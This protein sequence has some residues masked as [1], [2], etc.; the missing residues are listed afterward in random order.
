MGITYSPEFLPK[1]ATAFITSGTTYKTQVFDSPSGAISP[2]AANGPVIRLTNAIA[3]VSLTLP[4]M[5]T[6]SGHTFYVDI[7]GR[8]VTTKTCVIAANGSTTMQII[9]DTST[10]A[11]V[12]GLST[13]LAVSG[14]GIAAGT[15]ISAIVPSTTYTATAITATYGQT[16]AV[17]A[18]S[19]NGSVVTYSCA[20][21]ANMVIGQ[22]VTI[23]GATN[24]PYNGTY[25]VTGVNANINFTVA[26]T[27]TGTTSS[28][29]A[30]TGQFAVT[31]IS[32]TGSTVTYSTASTAGLVVG[33]PI[34]ITGATTTGFNGTYNIT[35]I[36][37]NTSFSVS[38]NVTG[39][40]STA[41]ANSTLG[42]V[43]F[44]GTNSVYVGQIL[45]ISNAN[46]AYAI[47]AISGSGS[48]VT[49]SLSDTTNLI[50]GQ[51]ITITG[52]SVAGYNGTFTVGTVTPNVSFTVSGNSTTGASSTATGTVAASNFNNLANDTVVAAAS[53]AW[54]VL[55][56]NTVYDRAG[57]TATATTKAQLTLSQATTAVIPATAS[58][59]FTSVY[60]F[61]PTFTWAAQ[62]GTIYWDGGSAPT[63]ASTSTTRSVIMFAS[64]NG[65]D[66][67]GSL[68]YTSV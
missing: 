3:N 34:T 28:A 30:T 12:T 39:T 56:A 67:Y 68:L 4:S 24:T 19:G 47:T 29:T 45:S 59:F 42:N 51:T 22:Q 5:A 52:A 33:Q 7:Q 48:A 23:S 65:T 60:T 49:Y 64:P 21:T 35:A 1:S 26:S 10:G 41:T 57:S 66:F 15:T 17:T 32:G 31:A 6:T 14:A 8:T 55:P 20:N 43:V 36:V 38:S 58:A 40:T 9:P 53:S 54:F 27:A 2:A 50:S 11:G 25:L 63:L 13:G 62:A 16:Y 44:T 37:A 46:R 18:I 61:T